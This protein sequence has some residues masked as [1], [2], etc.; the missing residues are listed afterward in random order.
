[1]LL[2]I[3]IKNIVLIKD[4]YLEFTDGMCV[5]TGETGAGKSILLDS[6]GFVI[7]KRSTA[8]LLKSGEEK[9]SVTAVFSIINNEQVQ[10]FLQEQDLENSDEIILRRTIDINGKSKAFIN[11]VQVAIS[12]LKSLG[13]YLVE[14]N[15]QG[16]QT[17]L[18]D[19]RNHLAILDQY[20]GLSPE[21][22]VTKEAYSK[23]I[24]AKENLNEIL[25]AKDKII[26]EQ[27]YLKFVYAELKNYDLTL[28]EEELA[29]KRSLLLN[30]TKIATAINNSINFL[31]ADAKNNSDKLIS[32][33]LNELAKFSLIEPNLDEIIAGLNRALIEINEA[34]IALN[35][36]LHKYNSEDNNLDK[37][38]ETL[39]NLKGLARKYNCEIKDLKNYFNEIAEKL[40]LL[41]NYPFKLEDAKKELE[42]AKNEYLTASLIL[43]DKRKEVA[44]ELEVMIK[45]ELKLLKMPEFNLNIL[46]NQLD[47]V[48]YLSYGI[49]RVGFL[50]S[51]NKS[52]P[53]A[54][55]AKIASGGE[56]SRFL[57]AV[58][59]V[60]AKV[61]LIPTL[62]FDEIDVGIGGAT[63]D[64]VGNRLKL[65]SE[66]YQVLVVT[67]QPQVAAKGNLHIKVT[68]SFSAL[69]TETNIS[70]LDVNERKEEIARMLSGEIVTKEAIAAAEKLLVC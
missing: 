43:S 54:P 44:Q 67:H 35:N 47:E 21:L 27:D 34:E 1:M 32:S 7:G 41:D 24:L 36:L 60:L 22:M 15:G 56:M 42:N 61:N 33:A 8:R 13:E 51:M 11:D 59:V 28:D 37:I 18:L 19:Q 38:E 5:L 14:I 69:S 20:G 66:N 30:K 4:L 68:K 63:A 6:L 39:F 12:T 26:R 70:V 45:N 2:N 55:L 64:A 58:K 31:F 46:I 48:N 23:Y 17:M 57:L 49:D 40:L 10:F 3:T 53:L 65:L 16:E 25:L 62:I 9:G 52:T 50:V 29:N